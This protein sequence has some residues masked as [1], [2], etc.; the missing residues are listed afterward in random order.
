MRQA[1]YTMVEGSNCMVFTTFPTLIFSDKATMAAAVSVP[2]LHMYRTHTDPHTNTYTPTPTHTHHTTLQVYSF[3]FFSFLI[4][5]LVYLAL[6]LNVQ[7][8]YSVVVHVCVSHSV[9]LE[10]VVCGAYSR[11]RVRVRVR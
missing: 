9:S 11:V 10:H 1:S 7:R 4:L 2:L 8:L 3:V 5:I 6:V